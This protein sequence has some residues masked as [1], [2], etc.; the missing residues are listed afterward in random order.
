MNSDQKGI[1]YM[2]TKSLLA[3]E[4]AVVYISSRKKSELEKVA[5]ELNTQFP[6]SKCIPID[7]DLGYAYKNLFIIF[8]SSEKGCES[9]KQ[10]LVQQYQQEHLDILVNNSGTNWAED[11]STYP[12]SAFDKLWALNVKAVFHMTKHLLP[13]LQK[14]ASAQE[15]SSIINIGSIHG[16]RTPAVETYAYSATKAAV[17][18]LT[19]HLAAR[20]VK[21]NINVNAIACGMYVLFPVYSCNNRFWTKMTAGVREAAEKEILRTVPKGR[22]GNEEDIAR[23]VLYLSTAPWVTGTILEL[24]GGA[25]IQSYF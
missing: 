8:Y 1:G 17:H 19:K 20:L 9:V 25:L 5:Q 18:H 2:I 22:A 23:A 7:A 3:N 11:I 6:K 15:P 14:R 4:A 10:R 13:L 24:E 21:N 12:D 16:I